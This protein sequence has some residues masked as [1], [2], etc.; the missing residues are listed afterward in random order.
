MYTM[1]T[2]GDRI[3]SN[4]IRV[5]FLSLLPAM[6]IACSEA[7]LQNNSA[8]KAAEE[9]GERAETEEADYNPFAPAEQ[10]YAAPGPLLGWIDSRDSASLNGEWRMIIDPMGVGEPGSIFG[11]YT[12]DRQAKTPYDLIEYDY[13]ASPVINVPGDFNTQDERLFFYQGR[14]WYFRRFEAHKTTDELYHL[15]FGG[16][17]FDATVFLNGEGIGRHKGGYVPFSFDVTDALKTGTNTLIIR[18]DNSLTIDSVPTVRTDWWPYG[19]LTRDVKLV[20]TPKAFIRNAKLELEDLNNRQ[21]GVEIDTQG[22]DKGQKIA[23][24]IAELDTQLELQVDE[25]GKASGQFKAPVELW[26]PDNPKLYKVDIMAGDSHIYDHV[27]FRTI[28]TIGQKV[29]LNGEPIKLKGISTH[30]EAIARDGVAYSYADMRGLLEEAKALNTNFV[31]AAHYPY[32]RHL[33]KVA[34]E[35]GLLLWEEIP[36]Y[37]N[38]NWHNEE[39][40]EIARNMMTRMIERDWNRASVIIW[41]V[42]NETPYSEARMKFLKALIDHTRELDDTRLVSAALLGNPEEELQ[43]VIMHL[44]ARGLAKDDVPAETKAIFQFILSQA[45][46]DTPA[47]DDTFHLEISDPLGEYV[48]IIAYNEYFGWYY[49]A[50]F[51]GRMGVGEDILRP[52]MLDFMPNIRISAAYDKP[53]HISEFGAGAKH[54]LRGEGVWSEDY[55]R[56]VYETQLQMLA[57]SPQVQG[58]TPWILKDFRA[59]LRTLPG[60]QDY[61]N[62]KGLMDENG[63][64]KLAYHTLKSFYED[65]WE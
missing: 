60:I 62:R 2:K 45:G 55:Q 22:M 3:C 50:F 53:L 38:I 54:G 47:I 11:G 6:I 48:D 59:M 18:I 36:V 4:F 32:S 39:T 40:L 29:H 52:L 17:N 25:K 9:G 10:N 30:E 27:G 43:R 41:S 56:R 24:V 23:V 20:T 8:A 15:W 51:S 1:N 5:L 58:I 44:A 46:E 49:S 31:R 61:R 26:S 57:N 37:W 35:L 16:A 28:K 63:R 21:I 34:D 64:R 33:A 42:A 7:G 14:V 65:E 19:G 12:T 13:R